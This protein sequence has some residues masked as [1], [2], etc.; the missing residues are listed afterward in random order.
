[1][2]K[3]PVIFTLPPDLSDEAAYY[4]CEL[5]YEIAASLENH[6]A[7]QLKSYYKKIEWEYGVEYIPDKD[8]DDNDYVSTNE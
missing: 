4:V 8:N 7:P 1:M 6:Y 2:R 3:A 5:F